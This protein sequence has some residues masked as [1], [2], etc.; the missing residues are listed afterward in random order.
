EAYQSALAL[1][2]DQPWPPGYKHFSLAEVQAGLG[3][4]FLGDGNLPAA[5][6]AFTQA[7]SELRLI[8]AADEIQKSMAWGV[9]AQA[10]LGL[11]AVSRARRQPAQAE[12]AFRLAL[13][14]REKSAQARTE[15]YAKR[16]LAWLLATCPDAKVR[17]LPRAIE[18]ARQAVDQARAAMDRDGVA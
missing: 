6:A 12:D 7:L 5:E 17:D 3:E 4:A 10:Q 18:V 8:P 15:L 2:R 13:A 14:A 16:E 11:G 1:Y 9:M